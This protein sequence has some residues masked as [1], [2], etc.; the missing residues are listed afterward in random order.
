MRSH[1]ED[2]QAYGKLK[3]NLALKYPND[4]MSYCLGK[5]AFIAEI[6][7]KAGWNGLRIVKALTEREWAAVRRVRQEFFF[8][9]LNILDPYTWTFTHQGHIHFVLYKGAAIIGYV[10]LQLW[11]DERA[12]LRIIGIDEAYRNNGIGG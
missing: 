10:H 9:D 7:T 12:A 4:I 1:E 11:P 3:E 2:R 6:D 8:D 5:E